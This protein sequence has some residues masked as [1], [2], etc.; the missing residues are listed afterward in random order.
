MSNYAQT[1]HCGR[2]GKETLHAFIDRGWSKYDITCQDCGWTFKEA[3]NTSQR[4]YK[5]VEKE[6]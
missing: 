3:S 6:K 5:K 4:F 2:C 1:K